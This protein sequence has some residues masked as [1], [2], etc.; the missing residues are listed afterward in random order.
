MCSIGWPK[1]Y[2]STFSKERQNLYIH[3]NIIL[4]PPFSPSVSVKMETQ[5]RCKYYL[6]PLKP[7]LFEWLVKIQNPEQFTS[8]LCLILD[9]AIFIIEEQ[10]ILLKKAKKLIW[11]IPKLD[12][13]P[14]SFICVDVPSY[15]WIN[16]PIPLPDCNMIC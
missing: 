9:L 2:R 6:G 12:K 5:I 13:Y 15:H 7:S 3:W 4:L 16:A 8:N 11:A 1:Q 10:S 14:M